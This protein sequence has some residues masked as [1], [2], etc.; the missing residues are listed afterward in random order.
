MVTFAKAQLYKTAAFVWDFAYKTQSIGEVEIAL[1]RPVDVAVS[2]VRYFFCKI[3]K[4]DI[5]I[6]YTK[7]YALMG[8]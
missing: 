1:Q 3:I 2:F 4:I 6:K 5:R 8:R 7:V